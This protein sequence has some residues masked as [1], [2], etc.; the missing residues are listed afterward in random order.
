MW[1]VGLIIGRRW[2]IPAGA[3]GWTLLVVLSVPIALGE[4]PAAAALGAA[5]VAVGVLVRMA[6]VSTARPLLR[7]RRPARAA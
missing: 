1:L 5:N 4:L 3:V 2:A 7:I 6:L